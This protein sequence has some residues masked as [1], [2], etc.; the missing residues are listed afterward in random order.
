LEL[1]S[2]LC[3]RRDP[4]GVRE[5]SRETNWSR[6]TIQRLLA[7]LGNAGFVRQNA[8]GQYLVTQRIV[9]LA[10][11]VLDGIRLSEVA[12]DVL[13]DVGRESG[14]TATL[15]VLEGTERVCIASVESRLQPRDVVGV[16]VRL[17]T[18]VGAAGKLLLAFHQDKSVL[19]HVE[20]HESRASLAKW[21]AELKKIQA[22]GHAESHG[23]R[24]PGL[25]S[26]AAPVVDG[27]GAVVAALNLS[28]PTT[29]FGKDQIQRHIALAT[30]AAR[31]L[32]NELKLG[33]VREGRIGL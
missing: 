25:S 17:P 29:R 18:R 26:V 28:G 33:R 2:L 3:K 13:R 9:S 14:E 32:S 19:A 7:G 1:L 4:A 6:S 30:A 10:Q 23:E 5:L 27:T 31:R 21:R 15:Y 22:A 16:G 24:L 8:D 20:R 11:D 12:M